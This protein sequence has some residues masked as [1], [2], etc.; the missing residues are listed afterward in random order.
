[1][2]LSRLV[3]PFGSFFMPLGTCFAYLL[4]RV[5]KGGGGGG[6]FMGGRYLGKLREP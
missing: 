3:S 4:C 1:M 6:V 5:L 2:G